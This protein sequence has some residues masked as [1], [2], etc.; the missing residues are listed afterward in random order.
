MEG[1]LSISPTSKVEEHN[2]QGVP[3]ISVSDLLT[4]DVANF[5]RIAVNLHPTKRNF[6][7]LTGSLYDLL[8]FF[9][10]VMA[11]LTIIAFMTRVA[12]LLG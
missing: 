12:H 2:V 11:M 8:R 10:P 6:G 7:S 5:D 4:L 1:N 3:W 9:S